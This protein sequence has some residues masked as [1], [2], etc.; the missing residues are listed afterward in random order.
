[1]ANLT[2]KKNKGGYLL[3]IGEKL[4]NKRLENGISIEE[5]QKKTKIRTKYLKAIEENNFN[6]IP[7]SVY[8][9]AFMK[10]YARQLN[11]DEREILEEYKKIMNVKKVKE[12]KEKNNDKNEGNE[13]NNNK[14]KYFIISGSII[15]V[16]I[17]SFFFYKMVFKNDSKQVMQKE[18]ITAEENDVKKEEKKKL[19]KNNFVQKENDNNIVIIPMDKSWLKV[20]ADGE[21]IFKDF[22]SPGD[23][24]EFEAENK[25]ELKIGNGAG[26]KI[27]V[28]NKVIG[29]LGNDGEVIKVDIKLIKEHIN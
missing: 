17:L 3:N 19:N 26:I 27:K 4:K 22:I 6:I 12:V 20:I 7:G 29:P 8:A 2:K 15:L 24:R 11:I 28:G 10:E 13:N 18:V 9:K 23:N 16:I 14:I 21:E 5:I 1:M 25:L